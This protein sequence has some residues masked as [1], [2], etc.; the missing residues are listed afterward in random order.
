LTYI[1]DRCRQNSTFLYFAELVGLD[2]RSVRSSDGME[3]L[4]VRLHSG[5]FSAVVITYL[6]A[7]ASLVHGQTQTQPASKPPETSTMKMEQDVSKWTRKQWN[8]AKAKWSEEKT[9]WNDCQA[10]AKAKKR[11]GRKSWPFLYDCM[12]K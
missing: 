8:A 3:R 4:M 1:N 2:Q 11:L 5:V 10:Q 12:T 7:G 6:A 9:Q